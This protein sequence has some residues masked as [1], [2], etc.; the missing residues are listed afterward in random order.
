MATLNIK[1]LPEA[2]YEKLKARAK[3]EG[4]SVAQEVTSLLSAVLDTQ[5]SRS[6]KELQG[7][8]KDLWHDADAPAHVESERAAWD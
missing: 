4:R 5:P 7:L 2:L 6:I 1:D 8:G 3:R